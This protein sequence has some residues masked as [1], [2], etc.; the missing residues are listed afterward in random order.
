M[1]ISVKSIPWELSYTNCEG[2][3]SAE[4]I[5]EDLKG[6]W[7]TVSVISSGGEYEM[8]FDTNESSYF[9]LGN[10]EVYKL[11]AVLNE[12]SRQLQILEEEDGKA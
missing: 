2:T 5:L 7:F 9:K 6:D 8:T 11:N 3:W 4:F 10:L 12:A 1:S